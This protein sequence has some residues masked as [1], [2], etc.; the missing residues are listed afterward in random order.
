MHY[1]QHQP[2]PSARHRGPSGDRRRRWRFCAKPYRFRFVCH[3]K[4]HPDS[5]AG[6]ERSFWT[7]ETNFLPGRTFQDLEDL[8]R[9]ALEWSTV[10]MEHRPQTKAAIIPAKA[11]E[12]E[13][14]LSDQTPGPFARPL[15][16]PERGTDQ[17]GYVA[18]EG[19][20]YWV[21]GTKREDVKVLQYS[22]RLKIYL[23]RVRLAEYP[24]PADGVT[25]QRFSPR[26]FP[27]RA[28]QPKPR[29]LPAHKR[30]SGCEPWLP[31]STPIWT[32]P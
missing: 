7:T 16:G 9:Q 12:H 17:Y 31:R 15:S 14:R 3:E 21:P 27:L 30:K 10:R 19:N 29:T 32:S 20:Y 11:F 8:N 18:F 23:A 1:R 22:D 4:G 5:K 28:H 24:L 26:I 2:G 25:N 13:R 6:E